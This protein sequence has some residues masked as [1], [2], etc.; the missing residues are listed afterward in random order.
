[1]IQLMEEEV[2]IEEGVVL[3]CKEDVQNYLQGN[4]STIT[5]KKRHNCSLCLSNGLNREH[6]LVEYVFGCRKAHAD[7]R[8]CRTII[9]LKYCANAEDC[10]LFVEDDGNNCLD[11]V[12][13]VPQPQHH[14]LSSRW[15]EELKTFDQVGVGSLTILNIL[16]NRHPNDIALPTENQIKAYLQR[17]RAN[18][19]GNLVIT[20]T[21]A[22]RDININSDLF[23]EEYLHDYD[24]NSPFAFGFETIANEF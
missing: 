5:S 9:K 6:E 15:K 20:L 21:N 13:E 23:T 12:F 18:Q 7:D 14:G 2:Q 19:G 4:V 3:S 17:V 24:D 10:K 1:M 8:D 11:E 16:K 22:I